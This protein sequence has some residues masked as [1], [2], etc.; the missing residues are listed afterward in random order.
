MRRTRSKRREREMRELV[1]GGGGENKDSRH[2]GKIEE[3]MTMQGKWIRVVR[4]ERGGK[5][6]W[7]VGFP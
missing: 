7:G 6:P 5:C 2:E 4:E 3:M 1:Q